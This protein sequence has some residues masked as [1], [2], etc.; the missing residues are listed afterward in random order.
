VTDPRPGWYPDPSGRAGMFRWWDG[1]SWTDRTSSRPPARSN[2]F[3]AL[4][5]G[6]SLVVSGGVVGLIGWSSYTGSR[7]QNS[8][9]G[10]SASPSTA[11]AKARSGASSP[12]APNGR[13]DEKTR[14]ATLAGGRMELPGEPYELVADPVSVPGVFDAMF[15]ANAPVHPNFNGSETWAATVGLGHIPADAWSEDD[16]PGFARKALTGFSEQ[17][18]GYHPTSVK[19]INYGDVTVSGRSC[20][21]ISANVHYRVKGLASRYD[22]LVII[23]CPAND[24]SVIA[25]ISSV[26]DDAP[27]PLVAL[28]S[29][30]LGTLTL[31]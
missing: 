2:R 23:G 18:F 29:E 21:E 9:T 31:G 5:V 16:L 7:E 30:S 22:R 15:V 24:G 27:K 13:L 20:A 28:A 8:A 19:K 10:S 6:V 12:A 11:G 25:A 26:P 3:I 1:S 17:F 14:H 4:L